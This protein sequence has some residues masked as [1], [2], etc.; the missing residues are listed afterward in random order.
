MSI[1]NEK[2]ES[3]MPSQTPPMNS[4]VGQDMTI[5][6]DLVFDSKI[7]VDGT[8]DGNLSGDC[9]VLSATGT[10]NGDIESN[11]IICH[12]KITGNV[13]VGELFL[14]KTGVINGRVETSDLSVESGGALNGEIKSKSTT[15]E[16]KVVK[17]SADSSPEIPPAASLPSK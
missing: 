15:G 17:G 2:K 14:K 5:T 16:F 1:F 9:L 12:G 11:T 13:K 10:V 3:L 4:I 8:I 6:G 7:Q